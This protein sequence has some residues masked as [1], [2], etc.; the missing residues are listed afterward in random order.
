M[1]SVNKIEF[2]TKLCRGKSVLDL[3]CVRHSAEFSLK[4]PNWLHM[5]LFNV[6][7]HIVGVDYLQDEV[8]KINVNK[9]L[10]VICGDVTKPLPINEQFDV[11]VAGDLIEHL[12]NFEGFFE[13]VN[14]LLNDNGLL[15]ITTPNPFYREEFFHSALKNKVLVNPEHTC[16]IDPKCLEQLANRFNLKI[17]TI[18]GINNTAWR[19]SDF[20]TNREYDMLNGIWLK[21]ELTDK[22]HRKIISTLFS[23]IYM[24]IK[25]TIKNDSV[26]Y[27]DYLAIIQKEDNNV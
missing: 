13:N 12:S 18:Y 15:I 25:H 21:D 11:I 19:L 5:H 24:P 27:A 20:I 2:I 3:G 7:S 14:R 8:E 1:L 16:W 6:S 26:K 10:N 22:I 4:D 17:N 23:I 9:L